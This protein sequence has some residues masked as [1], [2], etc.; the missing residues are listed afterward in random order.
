MPVVLSVE[1]LL[2]GILFASLRAGPVYFPAR[3]RYAVPAT[4]PSDV[5]AVRRRLEAMGYK[6]YSIDADSDYIRKIAPTAVGQLHLDMRMPDRTSFVQ[7]FYAQLGAD[8]TV[9]A[10]QDAA[11]LGARRSDLTPVVE[12][13]RW[14]ASESPAA[15]WPHVELGWHVGADV[16]VVT[17][18]ANAPVAPARTLL[19]QLD[20]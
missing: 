2:G 14:Y 20:P 11:R 6:Q 4:L 7:V 3:P 5:V 19:E 17:R 16:F 1:L 13:D 15:T 8:D 10:V 12:G 9:A 18:T